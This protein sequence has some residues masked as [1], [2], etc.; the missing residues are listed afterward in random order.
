MKKDADITV[1]VGGRGSGKTTCMREKLEKAPR[2]IVFDPMNDINLKGYTRLKTVRGV[3]DHIKKNWNNGF[4]IILETGHRP[5]QCQAIMARFC[6]DLFKIQA[7]YKAGRAD[8]RGKEIILAI[9]E[10]HKFIPN[11]PSGEL[12]LALVDMIDLGRHYG[13]EMI[14]ASQRIVKLWTNLRGSAMQYYF[15]RQGDHN[16]IDTISAIIGRENKQKLLNL[17]THE[18]LHLDK[19][20]G[21]QVLMGKNKAKFT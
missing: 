7:P 21:L 5:A 16:D 2:A 6:I 8:M 1:I 20:Q 17:K 4:R 14:C 13:I 10:A 12:E 11:P 18:F 3:Y 9:D 19:N 15:F